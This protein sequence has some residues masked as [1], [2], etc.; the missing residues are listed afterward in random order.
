MEKFSIQNRYGLKIVGLLSIPENPIGLVFVQH[1]LG[2]FKEQEHLVLVAKV[3]L[4]NQYIVVNFDATNSIGESEGSYEDITMEKHYEDLL[5][6]VTWAKTQAWYKEP[7]ILAGHSLGG[8]TTARYAEEYPE[9]IKAVFPWACVVSGALNFEA[10]KKFEPEKLKLWEETGWTTRISNSKPGIDLRLPWSHMQERLLHDLQP[11]AKNL[12][13]PILLVV[14][15]KDAPCPPEHQKILYD[16]IPNDTDKEFHIIKDA[17]HTF[18]DPE[19]LEQLR[20]ILD[21]WIKKL[22]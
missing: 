1:G 7:F 17:P 12:T 19:H 6:V 11:K 3:F 2:G 5:D 4:E 10:T 20:V 21:A 16:L 18:R 22:K 13:M 8:Y 9:E 14:G 15:E